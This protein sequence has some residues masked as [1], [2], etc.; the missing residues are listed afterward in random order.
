MADSIL[1]LRV[2]SGEYDSKI[3]RAVTGLQQMEAECRKVGGTL[4]VLEKDQLEYVKALGRMETVSRSA[5]GKLSELK[6][7]FTE[8]S[9][10][11]NRLTDEE[12][13]GDFGK[14]LSSSLEQLKTRIGESKNE[15]DSIGKSLGDAGKQSQ[16]MGGF[17]DEL[18][19]RLTI[20]ID[21]MKL[22]NVGLKAAETALSVAKDAFFASEANVDEWGRTVQAAQSV[23]EGFLTAIN[24]GDISGFLTRIDEIVIAAR[25]AYNELDTL[26]TMKTIQSPEMSKQEAENARM[27]TMLMTGRWISAADGRK[28]SNGLKDGDLLTKE[29]L[30]KIEK[31][32]QNGMKRVVALTKNEVNQAGKAI[33]AYYELLAKN[34]GISLA[35]FRQGTSSW[36]EFEKRTNG[37]NELNRWKNE[38]LRYNSLTRKYDYT[39]PIPAELQQYEGWDTFRVDKMGKNSYNELVGLIRQRSQQQQ[40]M[41]STMGQA[42]RTMNRVEGIT[43]RSIM[44]GNGGGGIGGKPEVWSAIDMS[45]YNLDM[46]SLDRS[47]SHVQGM[48]SDA[49]AAYNNAGDEMGRAAAQVI[50]DRLKEELG[51]IDAEGKSFDDAYSHDFNKDIEANKK[52]QARDE[53]ERKQEVMTFQDMSAGVN[54]MVGGISQMTESLEQMGIDLPEGFT[55]VLSGMQTI[56]SLLSAIQTISTIQTFFGKAGGGVIGKAASGFVVPG[57]SYSGDR[58][59][60]PVAGGGMIGVNS[61]E[62]VLNRAQAGVIEQELN[63]GGNGGPTLQPYVDGEKIWL[64]LNNYLRRSGRGEIVT[65]K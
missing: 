48:L 39:A 32:L 35:E 1:R 51:M 40:Q 27:R 10:Q 29:Q 63:G 25:K 4:A 57:N 2:Q 65:G 37:A 14:A 18:A 30:Q 12:K 26:G 56:A 49:T 23:Y 21:A 20:N 61:G 36:A 45:G 3:K 13:K 28:S 19:K 50:V 9:V 60:L 54:Q 46:V 64:G 42:Y 58:L 52:Q 7:A 5:R 6:E 44:G 62:V 34:N 16:Q 41:Y 43:P 15:L 8:L 11:Y 22:F 59:R 53:K 55:A 24:N 17:M 38:H 33:D 31:Q 47:R